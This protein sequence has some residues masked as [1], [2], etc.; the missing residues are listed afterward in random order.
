MSL[1]KETYMKF[2]GA[3]VA[4]AV[5][6]GGIYYSMSGSAEPAEGPE[7]EDDQIQDKKETDSGSRG[8]K[9]I[10]EEK[11]RTLYRTEAF[12]RSSILSDV[13]YKIAY[14]LIRGG[15]TFHG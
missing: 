7:K 9:D 8:F 14:G 10:G 5:L 11:M 4:A 15:K 2:A 1:S 13:E 6:A 12:K 3:A